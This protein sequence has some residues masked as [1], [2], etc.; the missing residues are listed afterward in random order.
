M[1]CA[2]LLALLLCATPL[3]FAG[4]FNTPADKNGTNNT[5]QSGQKE[6]SDKQKTEHGTAKSPY[7]PH[8]TKSMLGQAAACR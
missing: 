5:A 4:Y 6:L 2:I 3:V 7:I 1:I 8:S